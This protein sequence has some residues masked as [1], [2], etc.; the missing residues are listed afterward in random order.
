MPEI[1]STT[2]KFVEGKPTVQSTSAATG[3]YTIAIIALVALAILALASCVLIIKK[4]DAISNWSTSSLFKDSKIAKTN[5]LP[6]CAITI[7]AVVIVASI[8]CAAVISSNNKAYADQN[9]NLTIDP[10]IATV[11]ADTH[12]VIFNSSALHNASAKDYCISST[13]L[14]KAQGV[15]DDEC[16]WKVLSGS[17]Q[18]Y[19]GKATIQANPQSPSATAI[20]KANGSASIELSTAGL[21]YE[22]A[23]NLIGKDVITINFETLKSSEIYVSP[24]GNDANNGS[25]E[26]PLKSVQAAKNLAKQKDGDVSVFFREGNY[27]IEQTLKFDATDKNNVTYKAYNNE[28]V[29]FTS[30]KP[31]TGFEECQVNGVRAFKK[32]VGVGANFNIL[33][34]ETTTLNRTRYPENGYLLVDHVS[35]EDRTPGKSEMFDQYKGFYV[36]KTQMQNFKNIND[37]VVRVLHYWK[38]ELMN[39][40]SYDPETGHVLLSKNTTMNVAKGQRVFFENVFEMLKSP[41]QWYL[42]KPEGILYY[43]PYEGEVAQNLTLWGSELE[44]MIDINEV[45]SINFENINFRCNG[46]N[47]S[48]KV[49]GS[50]AAYDAVPCV[51][52]NY[53]NNST[54]KNCEFHDIAGGALFL[55]VGVKNTV[56]DSCLFDNIGAQAVY[57]RGENVQPDDPKITKDITIQNNIVSGYGRIYYNAVGL[58]VIHANSVNIV[59]NEIHDGYYTAISV[60]WVWGYAYS[61]T[62]NNKIKDNLIYNI[63]QGW[64]SDMGGIYTLG[65]QPGTEISGNVIH[66]VAADTAQGGYGGW[67]IYLDEGSSKILVQNNLTYSCGSDGYHLHYGN[68]NTVKN[69]IFAMSGNSQIMINDHPERVKEF[70]GDT[71]TAY[72]SNNIYLSEGGVLSYSYGKNKDTYYTDNNNLFWDLTNGSKLYFGLDSQKS[73]LGMTIQDAQKGGYVKNSIIENPNF[74]NAKKFDFAFKDTSA[75]SKIN[76]TPWNYQQ[77]G[78]LLGSRIGLSTTGGQTKYND[79]A[80][81]VEYHPFVP[82]Q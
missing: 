63:G 55:G 66:N 82:A 29:C 1:I 3:D 62:Y 56:V 54:I 40:K 76:F 35:E 77:A 19:N 44:T 21:S 41:G 14:V 11:D 24:A 65:I 42:D 9:S 25:I 74:T 49:D 2:I 45:D 4:R 7:L 68:H 71:V 72:F 75:I 39:V 37:V 30:G 15:S 5:K 47:I 57:V 10:I 38:D 80:R 53:S 20:I 17:A 18:L 22:T 61:V 32:N 13:S 27:T 34:N 78:T 6:I 60:G 69:N 43:V 46:F 51:S 81:E 79:N 26:S 50:Q 48:P 23:Y 58:L 59:N 36:D 73:G 31:Y 12:S 28:K 70:E 16:D 33:F 52:Y 67:G 64:L 8:S